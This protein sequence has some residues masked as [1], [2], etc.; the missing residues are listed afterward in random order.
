MDA[1][2]IVLRFL[3]MAV[4]VALGISGAGAP[5]HAQ[6]F[7]PRYYP[8]GTYRQPPPRRL[9]GFD[10]P[11]ASERQYVNPRRQ[12]VPEQRA[13]RARQPS[14]FERLFGRSKDRRPQPPSQQ[15]QQ[16]QQQRNSP[17]APDNDV[18]APAPPRVPKTI[19][20]G[21]LGDSLAENVAPGLSDAL[22]ERPEVGLVRE[23]RSGQGFLKDAKE[24]WR[25][26]ADEILARTP[27]VAAAVMFVGPMDDPPAKKKKTTE[28]EATGPALAAAPWMETYASKV[29]DIALAF[30][31]KGIPLLWVGLPPVEDEQVMADYL[32][33]NDLIRQRVAALGGTFIDVWEGFV[34]AE[35]EFT[36]QGP[37]IDG[38]VVRLR[39]ADGVH[40]TRAGARKLGH[41]I[42]LELRT[43]LSPK[44]KGDSVA[45][46]GSGVDPGAPTVPGSSRIL[47]LGQAPRTPGALLVPP[48]AEPAEKK[49][50]ELNP[51]GVTEQD[52]IAPDPA[53]AP[54]PPKPEENALVTGVAIA[55][56]PGRADDFAWPAAAAN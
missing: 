34:N 31:Q 45:D 55:P 15:Q 23:I 7:E 4:V 17:G 27:P 13:V 48:T 10:G 3:L 35:E 25:M 47:L 18:A 30:R 16:Q 2:M 11:P 36:V 39:S 51:G 6:L 26:S 56:K 14:F 38:R 20:V 12:Y 53:A 19:F 44:D 49:A 33:L 21:V 43:I 52:G 32:F 28:V 42:E 46:L 37:D 40:F 29:D 9:P 24:T 54:E 1:A 50:A 5:A 41:Y 22:S 8:P